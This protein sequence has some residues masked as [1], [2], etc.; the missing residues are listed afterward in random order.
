MAKAKALVIRAADET[1]GQ[2]VL[3]GSSMLIH[4]V[5]LGYRPLGWAGK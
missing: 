1:V 5:A 2:V 3:A 4:D